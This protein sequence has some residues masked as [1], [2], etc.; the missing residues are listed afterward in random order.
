MSVKCIMRGHASGSEATIGMLSLNTSLRQPFFHFSYFFSHP[1]STEPKQ[2]HMIPT[3]WGIVI[4]VLPISIPN[5]WRHL[6]FRISIPLFV[7]QRDW[8][9]TKIKNKRSSWFLGRSLVW[10]MDLPPTPSPAL[11]EQTSSTTP[12][13]QLPPGTDLRFAA[14]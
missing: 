14:N 5:L 11:S 3:E 8:Q 9:R 2:G 1:K 6:F 7:T 13:P 4:W 10:T 12:G